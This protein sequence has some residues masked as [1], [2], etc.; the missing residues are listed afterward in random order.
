MRWDGMR[1]DC[2]S[3]QQGLLLLFLRIIIKKKEKIKNNTNSHSICSAG[4][5]LLIREIRYHIHVSLAGDFSV[6]DGMIMKMMVAI[7]L[8]KR[9]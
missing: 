3:T 6:W 5:F 1:S 2:D 7:I 4:P 8:Y 9:E